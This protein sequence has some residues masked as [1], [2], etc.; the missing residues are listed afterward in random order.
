[1][2]HQSRKN[3][4][5][6]IKVFAEQFPDCNASNLVVFAMP[7]TVVCCNTLMCPHIVVIEYQRT[8]DVSPWQS[9]TFFVQSLVV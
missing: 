4:F 9:E 6:L 7:S 5:V 3:T 1:M 2:P 8:A